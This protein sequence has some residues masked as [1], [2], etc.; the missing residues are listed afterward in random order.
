MDKQPSGSPSSMSVPALYIIT[1]G[2]NSFK[3]PS[4]CLK[5]IH[6]NTVIEDIHTCVLDVRSL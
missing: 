2:S 5:R 6:Y 4:T 1:S 3:A